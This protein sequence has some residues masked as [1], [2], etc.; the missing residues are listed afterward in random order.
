MIGGG[1]PKYVL[2]FQILNG[3]RLTILQTKLPD[4]ATVAPVIIASDETQLSTFRGDQSAYPVYLSIGNIEKDIR[5]KPSQRATLLIGYL[6][7]SPLLSFAHDQDRREAGWALFHYCIG[8][9]LEPLIEAG[10]SGVDMICADGFIWPVY[11]IL[12]AYVADYSDQCKVTCVKQGWCPKCRAHHDSLG[13]WQQSIWRDPKKTILV[14]ERRQ[15][16]MG[17]ADFEKHGL[18]P[19]F[20]PFWA[21][22]PHANIFSSITPDLLHQ[23]HKGVFKDHLIQW[24]MAIAGDDEIDQR[25]KCQ[26][27]HAGLRYFRKGI[28]KIKQWTGT[29][30]KDIERLFGCIIPG[31]AQ[32]KVV[33]A[34]HAI[35]D[36]IYYT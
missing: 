36:F 3:S 32:V 30:Y 4:G 28:S 16:G 23:L 17:L 34:A 6:P 29:E 18:R 21:N 20:K 12:A 35:L 15:K 25:F 24:C 8:R 27:P 31:A 2:S 11:P 19:V 22:L 10:K 13:V 9:I 7:T 14:L 5:R 33:T 26:V 1:I